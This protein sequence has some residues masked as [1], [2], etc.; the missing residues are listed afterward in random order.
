LKGRF[1]IVRADFGSA[2][3]FGA[4]VVTSDRT[5]E[6]VLAAATV[7][8]TVAQ[9]APVHAAAIRAGEL[10]DTASGHVC[11]TT[12]GTRIYTHGHE[13]KADTNS[14]NKTFTSFNLKKSCEFLT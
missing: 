4:V 5:V 1:E 12:D 10:M 14:N 13:Q 8:L 2:S 6:L 11:R 9:S 7:S 3:Q